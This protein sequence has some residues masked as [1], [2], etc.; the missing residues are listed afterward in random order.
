MLRCRKLPENA[1]TPTT[2]APAFARG[3]GATLAPARFAK[4][5]EVQVSAGA[6]FPGARREASP[7][8]FFPSGAV[9]GAA[10]F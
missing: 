2:T 1:Q 7:R 8:A 6:I 3:S 4:Q 5:I 10:T 9:L